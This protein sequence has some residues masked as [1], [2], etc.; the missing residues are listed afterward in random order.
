MNF[1]TISLYAMSLLYT[2]AGIMHFINPGFYI[3]ISPKWLP[4][5]EPMVYISG[6][7]E[8]VLGLMLLSDKTRTLSS[9]LIIAM[10]TVFFFVIHIPSVIH[11]YGG[12]QKWFWIS[13]VRLPLQF[14]LVWWAWKVGGS[15]TRLF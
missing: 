13:V 10:L 6:V 7:A 14:V 5:A 8:I 12:N 11:F 1:S 3:K 15:P 2:G 4:Y 9:L